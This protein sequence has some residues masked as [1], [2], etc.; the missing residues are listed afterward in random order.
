[1]TA[2]DMEMTNNPESVQGQKL[3]DQRLR[4]PEPVT[5]TVIVRSETLTVEDEAF[6]GKVDEVTAELA[7]MSGVVASAVNAYQAQQANPEAGSRSEDRKPLSRS[8]C[9][10]RRRWQAKTSTISPAWRRWMETGSG[11]ERAREHDQRI[12]HHRDR[13]LR[14]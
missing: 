10:A 14:S 7:S 9:S 2:G 8:P 12:Q 5:E 3:L 4:E 6:R 13:D 1:L 11:A